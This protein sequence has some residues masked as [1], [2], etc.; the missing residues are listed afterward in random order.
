[1]TSETLVV[2]TVP[3]IQVTE[4]SFPTTEHDVGVDLIVTPDEII[5][6][7]N[8]HRPSGVDWS[9]LSTE[10][11]ATIPAL[12]ARARAPEDRAPSPLG[13]GQAGLLT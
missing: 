1:M 6:C 13:T 7:P 2:T 12:M 8:P 11:I 9:A 10:K 5:T 3:P 4:T